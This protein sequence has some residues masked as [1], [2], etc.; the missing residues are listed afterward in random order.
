MSRSACGITVRVNTARN[1]SVV[2]GWSL[3][4]CERGTG[5][6]ADASGKGIDI[7]AVPNHGNDAP[8]QRGNDKAQ[9]IEGTGQTVD[10]GVGG[11]TVT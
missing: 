10:A 5:R 2:G 9:T 1:S 3:R 8:T 6:V 7:L 11:D 4:L